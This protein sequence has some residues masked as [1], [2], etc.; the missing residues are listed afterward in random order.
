MDV[1][2]NREIKMKNQQ[3]DNENIVNEDNEREEPMEIG[4]GFVARIL[5]IG[6]ILVA[7]IIGVPYFIMK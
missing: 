6:A 1:K 4:F 5:G 3:T 7:I 2:T